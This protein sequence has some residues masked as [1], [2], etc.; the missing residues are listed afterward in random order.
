MPPPQIDGNAYGPSFVNNGTLQ[1]DTAIL[2]D[3][4][5]FQNTLNYTN[6]GNLVCYTGFL[7]DYTNS[8]ST[9]HI[10]VGP[11]EN[12]F[13]DTTGLI[14]D[15]FINTGLNIFGF[16]FG[17]SQHRHQRQQRGQSRTD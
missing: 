7:F 13:N 8:S 11:G 5:Q 4:F 17:R 6:T 16:V 9:S 2:L 10:K 15:G 12:F 14:N 1:I 3:K